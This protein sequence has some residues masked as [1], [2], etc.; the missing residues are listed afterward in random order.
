MDAL[1]EEW[2]QYPPVHHLVAAYLGYKPP[3]QTS[4]KAVADIEDLMPDLGNIPVRKV[5]PLD[6]SA[7]EAAMKEISHV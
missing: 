2:K 5:T 7:F 1:N 3:V 6:D 4:A